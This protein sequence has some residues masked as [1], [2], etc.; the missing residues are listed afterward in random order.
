MATSTTSKRAATSQ[1]GKYTSSSQGWHLTGVVLHGGRGRIN[2]GSRSTTE[3][4][5]GC[6]ILMLYQ[7]MLHTSGYSY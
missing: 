2:R 4:L 3:I 5:Q 6:R 7:D 1:E